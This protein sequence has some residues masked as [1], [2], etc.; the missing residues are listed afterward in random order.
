MKTEI[1]VA[2]K[3]AYN[4]MHFQRDRV[5]WNAN[6]GKTRA[7]LEPRKTNFLSFSQVR[8]R[9]LSIRHTKAW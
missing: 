3:T 2:N 8:D 9:Y 6:R 1:Q 5:I 4:H 7:I